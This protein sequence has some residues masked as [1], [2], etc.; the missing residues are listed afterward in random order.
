MRIER[1]TARDSRSAMA[2]V[3]A[4]L[5]A[6]ALILA[7]RRVAG[8][9]EITAAIDVDNVVAAMPGTTYQGTDKP[10]P[11]A[12]QGSTN[13]IQLKALEN[14]LQ[15]LRGILDK[16]LGGRKWQ[17]ATSVPAPTSVLR[18]RLLRMGLSRTLA[19]SLLDRLGRTQRLDSAWRQ[20]LASLADRLEVADVQKMPGTITAVYGSTGVGKTSTV[21]R[22]CGRDIARLGVERVGLIT[23]DNYRMGAHE[24]LASF[25]DALGI[26]LFTADDAHS[27][28]VA[29][30]KM[31]GRRI[32]IDTAGMSQHDA[33]LRGQ[34]ERVADLRQP[35]RHVLVLA[36]SAQAS[37]C[38]ALAANFTP[39]ALSGAIISKLDEAQSLG[40]VLD[41]VI[42]AGL[43]VLGF[44]D[45]QRIPQDL[46]DADAAEL[47]RRAAQLA[48]VERTPAERR[49]L[50]AA[51]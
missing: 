14:E 15:R 38:R 13:D 10:R 3:R 33:R 11:R 30:R 6:D 50:R 21:A 41:V 40:G 49:T 31:Q 29:V 39:R 26:P 8:Q 48:D 46:R 32:Y 5:G 16:E 20:T 35:V 12:A 25:A 24:Q 27:L 36:A 22:L 37:Q 45:G 2:Q 47:V 23:L 4:E 44:S 19:G 7:N 43:P 28:S 34:Y 1:Y 18:Q 9:I 51:V 17:D 42:S